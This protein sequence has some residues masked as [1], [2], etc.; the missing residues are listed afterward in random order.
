MD[1]HCEWVGNCIGQ[2]NSKIYFH[3]LVNVFVHS[4]MGT[5]VIIYNYDYL[6]DTSTNV[7]YFCITILPN[8]YAI[9]E[10]YRLIQDFGQ[11]IKNNQ[12]LI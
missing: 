11:S 1:H 10:S 7:V 6:L 3:L 4:L 2:Y 12:T 9:Y 8:V 5:F